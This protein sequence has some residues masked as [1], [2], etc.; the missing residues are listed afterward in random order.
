M[1]AR[2]LLITALLT[3]TPVLAWAC[4]TY[5]II[6]DGRIVLCTVCGSTVLCQ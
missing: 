3:G 4:S 2:L 1:T 5:S 6:Q